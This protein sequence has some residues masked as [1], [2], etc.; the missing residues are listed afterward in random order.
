MTTNKQLYNKL[1]SY[2]RFLINES[3]DNP[4]FDKSNNNKTG[5][6]SWQGKIKDFSSF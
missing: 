2:G 4:N 5:I 3:F 1:L 6:E